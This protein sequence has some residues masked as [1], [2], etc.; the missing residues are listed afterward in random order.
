MGL[1]LTRQNRRSFLLHHVEQL[2]RLGHRV[3][4]PHQKQR[5]A[6]VG[7]A[8]QGRPAAALLGQRERLGPA[9]RPFRSST[10]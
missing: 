4:C 9:A 7:R 3:H 2:L 10:L 8:D 6:N 5:L 1:S